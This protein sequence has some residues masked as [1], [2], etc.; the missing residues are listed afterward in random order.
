MID[1]NSNNNNNNNKRARGSVT[2][3]MFKRVYT[4]NIP[5]LQ[6]IENLLCLKDPIIWENIPGF[7]FPFGTT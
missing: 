7:G 2:T 6:R 1:N 4:E 5:Y 3:Y